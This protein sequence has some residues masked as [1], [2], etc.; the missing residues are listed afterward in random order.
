MTKSKNIFLIDCEYS[1]FVEYFSR[2]RNSDLIDPIEIHK[3]LTNNDVMKIPPS[4]DIVEFHMSKKLNSFSNCRKSEFLYFYSKNISEDLI[5]NLKSFFSRCEFP[6]NF[7][8]LQED[9]TALPH[10]HQEFKSVQFLE[11]DKDGF[12]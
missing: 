3:R 4:E 5:K 6:V 11:D 12:T 8:L 1:R 7:Y 9:G 10:F 2:K